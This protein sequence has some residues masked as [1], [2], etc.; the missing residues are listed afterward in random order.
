VACPE[1]NEVPGLQASVCGIQDGLTP[2]VE[3]EEGKSLID[4]KV[5]VDKTVLEPGLEEL[6]ELEDNAAGFVLDANSDKLLLK[7]EDDDTS[8]KLLEVDDDMAFIEPKEELLELSEGN[9]LLL[10]GLEEIWPE[11]DNTIVDIEGNGFV[12]DWIDI[13]NVEEINWLVNGGAV[14]SSEERERVIDDGNC[15]ES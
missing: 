6:V 4:E 1:L 3:V 12:E 2:E 15:V 11:D 7:I 14:F 13:A 8:C 9:K 5:V 10:L